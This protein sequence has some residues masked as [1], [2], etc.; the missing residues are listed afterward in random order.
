MKLMKCWYV[1]PSDPSRLLLKRLVLI[2]EDHHGDIIFDLTSGSNLDKY[3]DYVVRLKEN[4]T[5]RIKLEF[6]VQREIISGLKLLQ[7]AYKGP[8]RSKTN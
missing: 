5:Y 2:P 7:T 1:E 6:F 8:L 4:S 3:K